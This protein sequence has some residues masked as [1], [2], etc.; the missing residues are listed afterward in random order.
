LKDLKVTRKPTYEE[1][2]K[3]V[4]ELEEETVR[5]KQ[6]AEDLNEQ[7]ELSEKITSTSNAIIVGL[8]KNHK[9]RI[10]NKGAEKITGFKRKEVMEK[11]W[12]RI[13]FKPEIFDEMDKVWKDAWGKIAHSYVNPIFTKNGNEKFISWQTTGMYEG[14]NEKRHM[15]ISIG[16]DIT[17]RKQAEEALRQSEALLK[18]TQKLT[19]IGGWE[20]DVEKQTMHWTEEVYR[21][22]GFDPTDAP[23]GSKE[24]IERSM[25][26]YDPEDR[27]VI[28]NAF[29]KCAKDGIAY[30]FNFPFTTASGRRIWIR[31]VA[32]PVFDG[33]RITKVIGNIMDISEHKH[34]EKELRESETK[35]RSMMESMKELI[36]ICSQDFRVEYMNPA[37]IKRTGR[38]ATGEQCFNALHDLD[39]RCPWC[40]H[41]KIVQGI[42]YE[43]DIVSPKDHRSYHVSNS[44]IVHEDGSISKMTIFRDTTDLKKMET[45]LQQAQK[46]EAIGKLAGGIAHD[47]NNILSPIMIHS[48]LA[49]MDI[50]P[51]NPLHHSLKEIFQ[52]GTRARDLVKQVLTFSR[53]REQERASIKIG[54]LLREVLRLLRS[55]LPSTIEIR[56]N[57]EVESDT[58]LADPTQIHQIIMNLGVN[59]GHAMSEKGGALEV[60]L[61]DE[62]LDSDAAEQFEGLNPGSH[63]RLTIRDTGHGIDP[64]VIN[65]I[66]EPYFTTKG[67]EGTGMGLAVAHGIVKSHGGDIVVESELRKGTTFHVL[68]PKTE[69]EIF[70]V[71]EIAAQL[72]GGTER[73]LIVDDEKSA[74]EGIQSMLTKLGYKV[75]ART[76]SIEALEAFRN[77][78]DSFDLIITDM[79]MPNMTGKELA[80]EIM[81][82]RS[83]IPI[84]LCTGFSDQIDEH[85]A[86]AM[87]ISAYLMKPIIMGKMARTIRKVL[88][89]T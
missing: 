15:L 34:A 84:I 73:I 74:I 36:Y 75:T 70:T 17:E 64:E 61:V 10:F 30:D 12:F 81:S 11:D 13:F 77:N 65:R 83:D 7:L 41:H 3:R 32:E 68:F 72:A 5:C 27:P 86:K 42:Y 79:T 67:S 52:A 35:Y 21:I 49:M 55:S 69:A 22:H 6:V 43:K 14:E 1:L 33:G 60:S 44:P 82:I 62:Y 76:S 80:K 47:F 51:D 89:E 24:H 16:E 37:M 4:I 50:S 29:K 9:I 88:D 26:C 46:M 18:V 53:M 71:S 23:Y 58:I 38:D 66:F 48:E 87:G 20:W 54:P 19:K 59:A 85:T 45:Q 31:T 28:L 56:E 40:M 57:I 39:E 25:D 78:P 63:L 8:D 2:E